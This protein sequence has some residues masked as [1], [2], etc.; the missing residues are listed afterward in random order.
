MPLF[1][2]AAAL[3]VFAAPV[4]AEHE[5][6]HRYEVTGYVRG[7]DQRPF[8][9]LPVDI[10]KDGQLIG[11]GRTDSEGRY[12]VRLHLHDS[13]IGGSLSVRA[14]KHQAQVR[15][16]AER[17]NRST[18]RVHYVNFIGGEVREENL[19]GFEVPAWAYLVAAPFAIWAAVALSDRIGRRLRKRRLANAPAHSGQETKRKRRR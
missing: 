6:D 4:R 11:S 10:R 8:D 13:D 14:G 19:F 9:G 5:V 2:F 15:M 18:Q 3:L 16:Q 12:S 7:A 1:A 17:G